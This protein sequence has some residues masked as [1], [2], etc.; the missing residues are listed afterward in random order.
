LA[1]TGQKRTKMM[2]KHNIGDISELFVATHLSSKGNEIF[3]PY[4]NS[5][6]DLIYL[7]N[8]KPVK[9]QVKTGTKV[10]SGKFEYEQV[11]LRT[12]GV[13]HVKDKKYKNFKPYSA[14]EIDELWVLG[15]HLWCFPSCV[16]SDKP[17]LALGGTGPRAGKGSTYAHEDYIVIE[18]TWKEPVRDIMK[19]VK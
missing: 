4:G 13:Y 6:A 3:F 8:N 11:R 10:T 5:R 1:T 14:E 19:V 18:G 16:F 7:D 12:R 15:T 17:S 9:V 2:T